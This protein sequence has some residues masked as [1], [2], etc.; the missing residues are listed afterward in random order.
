MDIVQMEYVVKVAEEQNITRAA[1]RL[2]ISQPALSR[3]I[4]RIETNLSI[5]L[6][7]RE[8]KQLVLTPLGQHVYEWCKSTLSSYS[9]LMDTIHPFKGENH[10]VLH[11]A[12]SGNVFARNIIIGFL[13]L[14]PNIKI[15]D[16]QYSH[17]SYPD[18]IHTVDCAL[19]V[20]DFYGSDIQSFV[21]Y[22]SPLYVVMPKSHPLAN[23]EKI[24]LYDLKDFHFIASNTDGVFYEI[25]DDMLRKLGGRF[26][27]G[28]EVEKDHMLHMLNEGMGCSITMAEGAHFVRDSDYAV[29]RPLADDFAYMDI[30]FAY[31]RQPEYSDAF[32]KFRSFAHKYHSKILKELEEDL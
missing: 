25:V 1:N 18:I 14:H 22:R 15:V 31:K 26:Q 2:H 32:K 19:S 24:Y 23:R 29:Y 6:F 17:T 4:S 7:R 16:F 5:A 28:T 30:H 3:A 20:K 9:D 27:I 13:K 11:I 21:I 10:E 8:G 12:C